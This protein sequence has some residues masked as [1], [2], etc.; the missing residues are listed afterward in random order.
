MAV[1]DR[2]GERVQD[3]CDE[4][5]SMKKGKQAEQPV[6]LGDQLQHDQLEW[7]CRCM[8]IVPVRQQNRM[9]GDQKEKEQQGADANPESNGLVVRD[10]LYQRNGYSQAE[11]KVQSYVQQ[12]MNDPVQVHLIAEI[13][14]RNMGLF[15]EDQS[16]KQKPCSEGDRHSGNQP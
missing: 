6:T 10:M 13:G 5:A 9:S 2:L 7:R 14:D 1:C 8:N 4:D 11:Q 12:G 3:C 16:E 15:Q